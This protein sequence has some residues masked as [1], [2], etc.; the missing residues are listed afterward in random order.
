[1]A[2]SSVMYATTL[3]GPSHCRHLSGSAWNTFAISRAQLG[4]QRLFLSALAGSAST[5][6]S[7][8]ARSPRTRL[9]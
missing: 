4:E 8:A 6:G 2:S 9:A 3:S 7:P 1:M 5:P